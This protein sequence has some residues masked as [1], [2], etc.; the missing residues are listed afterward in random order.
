MKRPRKPNPKVGQKRQR[1]MPLK[2]DRLPQELLDRVMQERA[3]GRTWRE[4][5]ELSPT[6]EEWEKAPEYVRA[7][8]PGLRLT[9]ET[10]RRW[11]DL[12]V[13]QVKAEMLA[14][15]LRAREVA[16]LFAGKPFKELPEAVRNALGDKVFSLMQSADEK[17]QAKTLKALLD[18]GKLLGQQR[19]LELQEE[20]QKMD[21]RALQLRIEAMREKVRKLKNDMDDPGKKKQLTPEELK[22]RVDE[23]YGLTA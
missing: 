5:E 23:I 2:M 6:F 7:Q 17:S 18:L 11:H 19:K 13:E 1:P 4:L 14:D 21:E 16:A 20:K 12:R 8:F 3:A 15:Q 10:L 9:N 22:Q